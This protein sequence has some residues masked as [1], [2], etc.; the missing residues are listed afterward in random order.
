VYLAIILGGVAFEEF[1]FVFGAFT[2]SVC[3]GSLGTA[4]EFGFPVPTEALLRLAVCLG[5]LFIASPPSALLLFLFGAGF[6]P[7]VAVLAPF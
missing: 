1:G 4:G 2:E 5:V 3:P 6:A 7:A